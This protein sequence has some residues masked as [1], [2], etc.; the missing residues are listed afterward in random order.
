M[1]AEGDGP[2]NMAGRGG[3]RA[4]AEAI[5]AVVADLRA[6]KASI[7]GNVGFSNPTVDGIL[8]AR[9]QIP[10]PVVDATGIYRGLM[11]RADDG[12][13]LYSDFP[14]AVSPC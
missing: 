9:A 10:Q 1:A 5:A 3:R 8:R 4:P 13:N 7:A 14:S 2:V 6:G 12:I 11:Y